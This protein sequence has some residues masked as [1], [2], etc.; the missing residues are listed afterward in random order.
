MWEVNYSESIN[1]RKHRN[2][3]F[4]Y[5]EIQSGKI[6]DDYKTFE[7]YLQKKIERDI[8]GVKHEC[9]YQGFKTRIEKCNA[10]IM[11]GFKFC[12]HLIFD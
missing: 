2:S 1:E 12:N 10:N 7:I 5:P 11:D 4:K 8:F 3:A 9:Q 6:D